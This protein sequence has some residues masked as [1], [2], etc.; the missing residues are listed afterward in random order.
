MNS[1][2]PSKRSADWVAFYPDLD[3]REGLAK[4]LRRVASSLGLMLDGLI[5]GF[6]TADLVT[7]RGVV[8]L[9]LGARERVF[10][11]EIYE[12]GIEWAAGATADLGQ[13]LR[14]IAAWRDGEALG[15]YVSMFPFLRP[16]DLAAAFSEGKVAEA[17]WQNLLG[18]R[19]A[20]E[21]RQLL[22]Q[23]SS[24][25]EVRSLFPEISYQ[26]IRFTDPPPRRDSRVF[27]VSADREFFRVQEFGLGNR[28]YTLRDINE[29][30]R[31]IV[32]FFALG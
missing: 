23:L 17:Q 24:F 4:S 29:V 12:S 7:D 26:N 25:R 11:I 30:V 16:G 10:I 18:S 21:C 3:M 6:G 15:D 19:H 28:D 1:A 32:E 5:D 9:C 27:W 31:R 20:S 13:A 2:E 14:A 8:S 22:V